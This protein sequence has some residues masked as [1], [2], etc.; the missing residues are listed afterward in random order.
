MTWMSARKTTI[1]DPHM[2]VYI[3]LL[4][5][6]LI[7]YKSLT[8]FFSFFVCTLYKPSLNELFNTDYRESS[9]GTMHHRN[10]KLFFHPAK[11]DS[12]KDK[13]ISDYKPVSVSQSKNLLD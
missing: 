13:K 1:Q 12:S 7:G 3:A 6:T 4:M 2:F 11:V 9:I 8:F 10:S 5:A